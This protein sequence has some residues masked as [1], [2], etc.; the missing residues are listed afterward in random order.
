LAPSER[1]AIAERVA[2]D[3]KF[4]R[5]Y[6]TLARLK[7]SVA[8]IADATGHQLAAQP[9]RRRRFVPIAAGLGVAAVIAVTAFW[10]HFA[11]QPPV[12]SMA[13][14][15]VISLAALPGRPIV[16]DL[17]PAGLNLTDVGIDRTGQVKSLMAVYRGS[18]GCRLDLRIGAAGATLP[19][20]AGT[21]RHVWDVGGL[22]YELVA[23]GMP[24]WRFTLIAESAEQATRAGSAPDNARTRLQ[25]ARNS[26]PPC[27]S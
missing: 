22:A 5:G 4:A 27:T 12:P 14:E 17:S 1:A 26:A 8:E 23:H 19:P 25:I 2:S 9:S 10:A 6:A 11:L 16:P 21:S 15:A 3:R 20:L 13:R 24:A 18:H 7:A